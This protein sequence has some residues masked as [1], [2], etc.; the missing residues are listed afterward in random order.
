MIA[1][2]NCLAPSQLHH[3][4]HYRIWL[5]KFGNISSIFFVTMQKKRYRYSILFWR[6]DLDFAFMCPNL[7]ASNAKVPGISEVGPE[8]TNGLE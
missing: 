3:Y 4:K 6:F 7:Y 2:S 8:A 1:L 5:F